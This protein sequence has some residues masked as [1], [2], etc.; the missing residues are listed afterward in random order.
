MGF[1][2]G[3]LWWIPPNE[4][5]MAIGYGGQIIAVFPE[6]IWLLELIHILLALSPT[7]IR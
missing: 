5:F 1:G 4:G 2:Y 3:Y 6:E 7:R